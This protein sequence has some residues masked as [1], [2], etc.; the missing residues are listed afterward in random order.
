MQI[1]LWEHKKGKECLLNVNF[2]YVH[3]SLLCSVRKMILY[4]TSNPFCKLL[5]SHYKNFHK[6]LDI[7]SSQQFGFHL[8]HRSGN[9]KINVF[10]MWIN[11]LSSRLTLI[12]YGFDSLEER[13][14]HTPRLHLIHISST[15]ELYENLKLIFRRCK[16][17]I[18]QSRQQL[19]TEELSWGLVIKVSVPFASISKYSDDKTNICS[20]FLI[21]QET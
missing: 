19:A 14:T 20:I 1:S 16:N 13:W 21:R 10:V 4:K 18:Q 15:T 12:T 3:S 9:D 8:I 17:W 2:L 7:L 11:I 5:Q 6:F